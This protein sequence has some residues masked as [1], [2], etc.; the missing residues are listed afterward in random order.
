MQRPLKQLVESKKVPLPT[1]GKAIVPGCGRG[2]EAVFIAAR[3]GLD[4][5]GMDIS[6]IAI[7]AAN[8]NLKMTAVPQDAKISYNCTNFFDIKAGTEEDKYDLAFDY[9]FFVA[10]PPALRPSWGSQM[11]QLVKKGG[12][13]VA[14][15]W[16][17][18]GDRPGGP[19]YSVDVGMYAEALQA[20]VAEGNWTK[21]LD[22]DTAN[23]ERVGTE[24][25]VVWKRE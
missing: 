16:P 19:P 20:D 4:T 17:I 21:V 12:Y 3:L 6:P 9:T 15:I 18:D 14:L 22:E 24:R 10:I 11:R 25:I 1:S 23:E 7:D 13:L 5:I 8:K 2:Y